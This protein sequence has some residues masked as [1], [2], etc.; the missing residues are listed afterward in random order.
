MKGLRSC[1]PGAALFVLGAVFFA[2]GAAPGEPFLGFT[3]AV[4]ICLECI[5]IG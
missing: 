2:V 1:L 3:K 4:N 5:G